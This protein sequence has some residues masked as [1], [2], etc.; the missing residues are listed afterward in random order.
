MDAFGQAGHDQMSGRTYPF[1]NWRKNF[2]PAEM[3][4]AP[5]FDLIEPTCFSEYMLFSTVR[6]ETTGV[7]DKET[8]K[9]KKG[10]ATGF[11]Y[12]FRENGE[13]KS[14]LVTNRHV[15]EDAS[16][17]TLNF[18]LCKEHNGKLVPAGADYAHEISNIDACVVNHPLD[19][20]DLCAISVEPIEE[21]AR[22]K[23]KEIYTAFIESSMLPSQGSLELMPV[24]QDVF[25][26]GYPIGLWD[27]FNNLPIVRKGVLS[28][29]P[30]LDFCGQPKGAVDIASFP[31]SSG[32]PIFILSDGGP[33]SDKHG[34]VWANRRICIFLGIQSERARMRDDGTFD[35]AA[36]PVQHQ[37]VEDKGMLPIHLGYYIKSSQIKALA[38]AMP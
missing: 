18:Q 19:D 32:S 4:E 21:E 2:V 8:G 9:I 10:T 15:F 12:R 14:L 6:I 26:Y 37:P 20:I 5:P 24:I 36:I 13:D 22:I 28:S 38:Q 34:N 1:Y 23:G 17:A 11:L 31:G 7:A 29:H 25:M 33:I 27:K 16:K 30:A 35:M 3:A